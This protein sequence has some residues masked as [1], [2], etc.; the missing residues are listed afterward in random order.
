M[1]MAQT[2]Q[3]MA[4]QELWPELP[5]TTWKPTGETLHMWTQI[6]GKIKLA[7]NPYVNH[8]W[9]VPLYVTASGLT[10][11]AIPYAGGTFEIQFNFLHHNLLIHTS[12]GASKTLRLYSRSVANFYQEV[13]T[14]LQ[15]LGIDVHIY[16]LPQ[17][18]PHPIRFEKDEVHATY[19]P[20]LVNRYWQILVQTDKV[21]QRYRS[22]FIG[23][24]SPIH[25]FWGSLDLAVTFFSGRAAPERP[26]VDPVTREAYSHEVISAGFWPG[27]DNFP[28]PAF[29]SYAAPIPQGLENATLQP[30]LGA[31]NQK[32][33][34]FILPYN[35]MR[36]TPAP[37]QTLLDFYQHA[38]EAAANLAHWDRTALEKR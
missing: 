37:A 7:L 20:L 9:Q 18:V 24:S 21:M 8:W 36:N 12:R 27:G 10:T 17:E 13:M 34:E 38:Y 19:D 4:N 29:Y 31:Y 30:A 28:E 5:F 1:T 11:S 15:A 25:L 32:M 22:H 33:G 6:I 3:Q 2:S 35:T 14:S 26:E 23:K 16:T